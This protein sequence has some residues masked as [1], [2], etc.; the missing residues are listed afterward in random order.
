MCF[1]LNQKIKTIR[2]KK[3]YPPAGKPGKEKHRIAEFNNN[4]RS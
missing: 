2:G 3:W 4:I 1:A